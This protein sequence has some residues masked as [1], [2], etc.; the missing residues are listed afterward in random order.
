[1]LARRV[2]RR[3]PLPRGPRKFSGRGP[4][5]AL[6]GGVRNLKGAKRTSEGERASAG[7]GCSER[8]TLNAS[9]VENPIWSYRQFALLG[10]ERD[11]A[12]W[13]ESRVLSVSAINAGRIVGSFSNADNRLRIGV[14]DH[15][16]LRKADAAPRHYRG[17]M[18][19]APRVANPRSLPS[20]E[21]GFSPKSCTIPC[22]PQRCSCSLQHK[23]PVR[24]VQRVWNHAQSFDLH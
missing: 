19:S 12:D 17:A 1:M 23:V 9:T 20:G 15:A 14:A 7:R 22:V 4:K 24:N 21:G 16:C 5:L 8:G 18:V 13:T 11:E 2:C 6:V 3:D 10:R